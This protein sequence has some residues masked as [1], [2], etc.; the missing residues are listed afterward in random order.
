MRSSGASSAAHRPEPVERVSVLLPLP[1]S[2]AYDYGVPDG[3]EVAPGDFVVAPLGRRSVVGVVWDKPLGEEGAEP[4]PKERLREIE[5]RLP[6]PPMPETLRRFVE[7]VA[8]YTVAPW[9]AVL[10]M[11][12]S[13]PAALLPPKPVL[14]AR[15]ADAPLEEFGLK[16]TP[17]RARIV[18]LL[19]DGMPRVLSEIADEAG[20]GV[21]VVRQMLSAGALEQVEMPPPPPF[22]APDPRR[23]GNDLSAAQEDAALQLRETIGA[24]Y[25]VTLLDGVTG[26]G[27]TEVYFEA[28]AAALAAGR[29]VLVLLP[30]IALSAQWLQRFE[31]RFGAR[32]AAWHSDLTQAERR[33]TWRAVAEGTA[34]LVVG[35][36]S[37]LFL[38]LP[39]LGLIIVD[40]EHEGAYKQEDGVHYHA[41]DMAVVRAHL[42]GIP[43]LLVSATPSLET[44][45]NV[46]AG[47][48]RALHLP[49]RHGGASM[50][51]VEA[52]DLRREKPPPRS[53][54]APR[55]KDALVETLGAG[56]QALLYLNRRGY[57]P[58]TL[59][60]ACGHRLNCPN[61]TAWL[62]EHRLAGRLQCHHCGHSVALPRQCPACGTEASLAA[63]GPGVERVAEEVAALFPDARIELLASD[64]LA[65]PAALG[66]LVERMEKREIDVLIGTQI[67]AKG[68]H[69]PDLTLVGVIDA[70]LG[71]A[72]GDLRAAERTFQLLSQVAGRAGRAERPGRVFLQT[73]DPAH[74]V[75][76]ALVKGDRDRFIAE[77]LEERRRA[78]MPP[79]ARLA[80]I[81]VQARDPETADGL[82]RA[83]GRARPKGEGIEV[84]GPAPAPFAVLR[85]WH[86]RRLLMR[87][88]RDIAPQPLIRRWLAE[89]DVPS[90]ARLA[91]D[92]DP[93][94]F[95]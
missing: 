52:I 40:E 42:A 27:K 62:V 30:E 7:W 56:E 36:R 15:A 26:S 28:I 70:D 74:P 6:A 20:V 23:P 93:Y 35:A 34:R 19:A 8:S 58:L 50:P 47:R 3:A 25:S 77:E 66:A 29:Q 89:V 82:A 49:D 67:V 59:C 75:I 57:A 71:L 5:E 79:F 68:H 4:V 16:L 84:L 60:K 88:R 32:P 81:I 10:R 41:R 24:G 78:W 48:Y 9:G 92:I 54:L 2:G 51:R 31:R 12:I 64:T 21:G 46:E 43:I 87:T 11:A 85:G 53:W 80:A 37:A 1:L 18:R 69:F 38:P 63:Y 17:A 72:G 86:R 94:S 83:L 33:T 22:A 76:A 14:A 61:C 55:L 91:V 65:G 13:A 73:Y 90:A 45:V 44:L 95:L 39:E